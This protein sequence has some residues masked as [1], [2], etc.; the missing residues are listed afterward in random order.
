MSPYPPRRLSAHVYVLSLQERASAA[1][2]PEQPPAIQ[3]LRRV[4]R[5]LSAP[6]VAECAA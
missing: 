1:H 6:N 4:L 2:S 5:T 3:P